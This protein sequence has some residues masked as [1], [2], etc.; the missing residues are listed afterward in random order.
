MNIACMEPQKIHISHVS[1]LLG[2]IEQDP[3]SMKIDS[4]GHEQ[5]MPEQ[6]CVG[7]D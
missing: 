6:S 5:Y 7:K 2:A 4:K 1:L 3:S